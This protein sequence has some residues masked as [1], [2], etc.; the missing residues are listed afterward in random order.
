MRNR[1][2]GFTLIELLVVIAIIA[3]LI[4]L[5]LPAVQA[6]RE[7]AR[8]AQCTNNLKQLGLAIHNYESAHTMLPLGRVWAPLPGIPFPSFFV[9]DRTRRGSPR[10]SP[11]SSSRPSTTPTTSRSASTA[12]SA[13]TACRSASRSIRRSTGRSSAAFQCPSDNDRTFNIIWPTNGYVI[14]GH[15]GQLR[16][17]LGQHPVGP[18]E[19]RRRH[20]D[21]Q[22]AG[23]LPAVGVRAQPDPAGL[24]HR[25][26]Q[27]YGLHGRDAPGPGQR[28]PRVRS[29]PW[30]PMF[31]SRFT[32]EQLEGLLR[33]R[34]PAGRRRRP[35]RRRVLRQRPRGQDALRRRC[36]TPSTISTQA[37]A[38][39]TRAASTPDS[40]TAR[41]GSSRTRSPPSSGSA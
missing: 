32:P 7:A 16:G 2:N 35:A 1:R 17:E 23:G 34:G 5:L 3:V 18:A 33:R 20:G 11:S 36:R 22:P 40:A 13:A 31:M 30:A 27:Q 39:G 15:A 8:R 37:R 29:G 4:A 28:R 21:A 10:C 12:R 9:G 24:D 19:L 38:A 25:R 14:A 6:A 26:D 41:C